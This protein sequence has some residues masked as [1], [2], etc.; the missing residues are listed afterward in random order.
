MRKISRIAVLGAGTMGSQIAAL[1]ANA[2]IPSLLLDVTSPGKRR[3]AASSDAVAKLLQQRQS[4]FFLPEL[5]DLIECGNF[6]DD[7][8]R[9][10][11]CEWIIE[12]VAE[13]LGI[14]RALWER[15]A[16]H[17]GRDTVLS[18]NTSGI[19]IGQI[20]RNF[21]RSFQQR[22]LGTHFFNPPRYLYL[23]EVIP[24]N[25]TDLSIVSWVS[26]FGEQVLGKGVV[27]GKDTPNFIANRIG[28][29]YSAAI[30]AAM[31]EG[32]YTIEDVDALTGPLI[33]IPKSATFR[34]IDI[35]GLDI[36]TQVAR[37]LY[38]QTEDVWRHRFV[39][40][41]YV[42]AMLEKGWLG[43]KA[44]QGFYRRYGPENRID[45]LD[46]KTLEYRP[47][48]GTSFD[49]VEQL[50]RNPDVAAR[51][52][53]LIEE[54]DRAGWFVWRVLREVFVYSVSMIPEI[55]ERIVEVDRAMR[56]GFGH[57]LG[58]FELW[59]ALGF[60]Q[61]AKRIERDG[62][63][64]PE[65]VQRMLSAGASSFY[66]KSEYFDFGQGEFRKLKNRF[67]VVILQDRK[68]TYGEVDRNE[69]ASLIDLGE[70]VLCLEFHSKMNA[71][72]DG[73]LQVMG[74]AVDLLSTDFQ[75]MIIANE[76]ETFS[77][78][79]N[80]ATLLDAA[81]AGNL[82]SIESFI[83]RFQQ[84]LMSLKYAPKPVV[85]AAFSRALG[86]GCEVVLHCHRVQAWAELYMG[87]VELNVGLIPAGGGT[88]EMA[89]RFS[90]PLKGF[91]LIASAKVS[92]SAAE[93][94]MLGLLRPEDRI[95]MNRDFLI[96]DAKAFALELANAYRPASRG[97]E[98]SLAGERGYERM[99]ER[100][101]TGKISGE[102]TEHDS[103]ILD[104]IAYVLSGGRTDPGSS[105]TEERLL[106]L[107]LE[108]FLSLC[109]MPKT[110]ERIQHILRTGKPLKN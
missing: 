93:A 13:E 98:I 2:G 15:V 68:D 79:A 53:S 91:D 69:E 105:I 23:L 7:L 62:V 84:A 47:A 96:G 97:A 94:R 77:A 39:P 50:R 38:I 27:V 33:G 46:W 21:P 89:L 101:E 65:N 45:V 51:I 60:P 37:N 36:W 24:G 82:S 12:A 35:I 61:I 109:E 73:T 29:F 32:E 59:D 49:R 5:A 48:K 71:I 90:D 54:N 87:L 92:G 16:V 42:E 11:E 28:S 56:W 72:G 108:A 57:K 30:Q 78:G 95:T 80:L 76:G 52:G 43:E 110:Q 102:F 9:V 99:R 66:R 20:A 104:R 81:Q 67:G 17:S 6:D 64:L 70:G 63:G 40:M 22:F 25:E 14:K 19:Q 85:C 44:G 55:C 106:D 8:P 41:P 103:V 100:I 107:E 75:A 88:K 26:E 4:A 34:L 1:F 3:N 83:R 10:G 18:T 74:R 31:V 58:P 86:G